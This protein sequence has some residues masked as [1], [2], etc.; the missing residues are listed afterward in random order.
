MAQPP[1]L[2][3]GGMV[4]VVAFAAVWNAIPARS[5]LAGTPRGVSYLWR[6]LAL[7]I[8]GVCVGLVVTAETTAV[9]WSG[10][11]IQEQF[12]ALAV[13]F[14]IGVAFYGLCSAAVRFG[15]DWLRGRYGE[16]NLLLVSLA[17]GA[18]GFSILGLS[19]SFAV[20]VFAFAMIGMG[21]AVSCPCL[22]VM[23]AGQA[24]TNRAA[25]MAV[26]SLIAGIPRV[27]APWVI[28]WVAT[29]TSLSYAFG[30]T[31]FV[32]LVAIVLVLWLRA[33]QQRQ[34]GVAQASGIVP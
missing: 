10:K 21:L 25:G 31:A 14:G 27:L 33:H 32:P 23:A 18:V 22:F 30:L 9:F 1:A 8:M 2:W 28:G 13:L 4:A 19:L 20:N 26:V 15:G 7:L 24:P 16:M 17:I 12:P 6:N 29:E 34:A 5:R 3:Q 11:L